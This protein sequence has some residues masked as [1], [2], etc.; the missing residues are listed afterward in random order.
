M[1]EP[2]TFA[3]LWATNT[4][5]LLA[6]LGFFLDGYE[7]LNS[8]MMARCVASSYVLYSWFKFRIWIKHFL[9][10]VFTCSFPIPST[11]K[12]EEEDIPDERGHSN[13]RLGYLRRQM[14]FFYWKVAGQ[15]SAAILY[16]ALVPIL[17]SGVN[18]VWF[19]FDEKKFDSHRYRNSL[20]FCASNLAF[21]ALAGVLGGMWIYW[22][23][24]KIFRQVVKEAR[25][26]ITDYY[27]VGF[28]LAIT[29]ANSFG[30][31]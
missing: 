22:R 23:R 7:K 9:K 1:K 16:L 8:M 10:H 31:W 14:R 28:V 30:M 3:I 25:V 6:N 13:N 5:S 2:S 24:R 17:R 21:V 27:W 4:I 20:I 26:L 15:C 18:S 12:A 29:A 11:P 19:I